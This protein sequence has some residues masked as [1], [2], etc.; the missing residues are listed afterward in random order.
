MRSEK[1][2]KDPKCKCISLQEFIDITKSFS[3]DSLLE[4]QN[5]YFTKSFCIIEQWKTVLVNFGED[6]SERLDYIIYAKRD[7][8]TEYNAIEKQMDFYN[9]QKSKNLIK[10][11]FIISHRKYC[12]LVKNI[13]D[14]EP[15]KCATDKDC[16]E[17]SL[18]D[19]NYNSALNSDLL[20]KLVVLD[21]ETNGLRKKDDDLLSISIYCPSLKKCYNRFL[22][23]DLQPTVKTS[24]INGITESTLSECFHINQV[25]ID[26]LVNYFDL[27]NKIVLVFSGTNKFDEEFL[28]NYL[29]RHNLKL[30]FEL[31][32]DNIKRYIPSN[33]YG[34]AGTASKDNLC[35]LLGVDGVTEQH[36]GL[37]DCL[38]EWKLFEKIILLRPFRMGKSLYAYNK[39]YIIPV[40][41]LISN[42]KLFD[43]ARIDYPYVLDSTKRVF[44]YRF[45][46]DTIS[47]IKKFSTNITGVSLENMIFGSLNAKKQDN[48]K[49]LYD[50]KK[51]LNKICDFDDKTL[52][53]PIEIKEDGLLEAK[54]EEDTEFVKQV[55][56][57]STA[58]KAELSEVLNFIKID[59]FQNQEICSQELVVSDDKKVLSICDL[60]SNDSILE[61]KTF[62]PRLTNLGYLDPAIRTQLFYQSKGRKIYLLYIDIIKG[63][64]DRKIN[65]FKVIDCMLEINQVVLTKYSM[66]EYTKIMNRPTFEEKYILD[67]LTKN[68][69]ATY[70]QIIE[71]IKFL[72]KRSLGKRISTLKA[73]NLLTMEG[74]YI[75][76]TWNVH[77]EC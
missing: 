67:F 6:I 48:F 15:Y 62:R 64:F 37:N 4:N 23:L 32:V 52:V 42:P 30:G 60:S 29:E 8:V 70:D 43:Y 20:N 1:L 18:V 54:L 2:F 12:E 65:D 7:G 22:P 75:E 73:K 16:F 33:L 51:K 21:V 24:H 74:T 26:R 57:V 72:N 3:Y 41:A 49:F 44:S 63:E 66:E 59:I 50:N 36:S 76:P 25:E 69:N 71:N 10:S 11:H 34:L 14:F 38:L 58:I 61:I 56:E 19:V 39:D 45:S 27:K 5:M 46:D 28:K 77:A 68:P 17:S 55:N 47:K 35:K 40:T 9:N 31:Q 13:P 53:I